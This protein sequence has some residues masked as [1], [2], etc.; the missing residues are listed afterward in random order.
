MVGAVTSATILETWGRLRGEVRYTPLFQASHFTKPLPYPC[1]LYLKLEQHQ[2]TGSFKIRGVTSKILS[3][4]PE[5][6]KNG[7]YAA[8]GGNHGRAVAYAG[9][10]QNLKTT[11]VLPTCTPQEKIDLIQKWG[12]KTIIAGENLDEA[13]QIAV[14]AALQEGALFMHPFADADVIK[15]QGTLGVELLQQNPDLDT[16]IIAIGGGGLISGVGT[17]LKA[18]KPDI[19]I[20]GVEPEGC[21]SMYNSLK[22]G[23]I[24]TVPKI[25]TR[26]GTLAICT[27]SD[28]NFRLAQACVDEIVLVT[29]EEMLTA[30]QRIWQEFGI[31]AELSGAASFAGLLSGKIKVD[32]GEKVCALIC[33]VGHEGL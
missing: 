12:A 16:V 14:K 3:T 31:A 32:P 24:V 25:H 33:G 20:I 8:S 28:I 2:I 26:V 6:L 29:D 23:K 21:A 4:D 15:G 1:D 30:S 19:R 7:I 13:T 27:T 17:Y 22:A 10:K 18:L 5:L 11:V 9:W